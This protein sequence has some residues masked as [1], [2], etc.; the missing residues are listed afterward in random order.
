MDMDS[1]W[2]VLEGEH[3]T[4]REDILAV[5]VGHPHGMPSVEGLV[6]PNPLLNEGIV[7]SHLEILEDAS[8]IEASN[9][10]PADR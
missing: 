8:C 10:P 1:V 5:I 2:R 3:G 7:R 6:H 4:E 9:H